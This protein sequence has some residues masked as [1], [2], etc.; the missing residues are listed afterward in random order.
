MICVLRAANAYAAPYPVGGAFTALPR[1]PS[2]IGGGEGKGRV[3]K[4]GGGKWGK[5]TAFNVQ[6]TI[7][8]III[9]ITKA[10]IIVIA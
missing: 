5:E 3:K 6:E 10:K 1:P 7:I 8:I 2:G 9:I 4:E